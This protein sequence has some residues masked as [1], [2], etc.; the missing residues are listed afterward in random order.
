MNVPEWNMKMETGPK[1]TR[2]LVDVENEY[3][4]VFAGFRTR[5]NISLHRRACIRFW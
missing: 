1:N 5:K 2:P 4:M 3:V